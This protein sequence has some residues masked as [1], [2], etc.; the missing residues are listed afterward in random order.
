M[1][2]RS[3]DL[4]ILRL[5]TTQS[6]SSA[7]L[8]SVVLTLGDVYRRPAWFGE[9]SRVVRV[10]RAWHRTG[11]G[12]SGAGRPAPGCCSSLSCGTLVG[13]RAPTVTRRFRLA[14]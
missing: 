9:S 13:L 2:R 3:R 10:H 1:R 5:R 7:A 4:V 6:A 12:C 8:A 14:N 11:N